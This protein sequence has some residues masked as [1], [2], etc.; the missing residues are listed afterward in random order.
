[1]SAAP[2]T[3]E[4]FYHELAV[5]ANASS[6]LFV[7]ACVSTIAGAAAGILGLSGLYGFVFYAAVSLLTGALL[8]VLKTE[9][10][11]RLYFKDWS[12]IWFDEVLGNL[13]SFV[14]FWTLAFSLVHVF[15]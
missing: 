5:R 12:G 7:R 14:L 9:G 11:P 13:F 1:M 6:I 10:K 4:N 3:R 15:E 8:F 2:Q